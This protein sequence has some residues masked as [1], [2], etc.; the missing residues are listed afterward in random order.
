LLSFTAMEDCDALTV[1]TTELWL[2]TC[3]TLRSPRLAEA[4]CEIPL[5]GPVT[6][7]G[8]KSVQEISSHYMLRTRKLVGLAL[9]ALPRH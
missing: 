9:E 3:A 6:G 4:E 7:R 5:I 1:K 8:S 2:C